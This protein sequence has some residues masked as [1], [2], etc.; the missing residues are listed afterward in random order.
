M[1]NVWIVVPVV[2]NDVDLTSMVENLSGGYTAP[3]T[4]N[5]YKFDVET[6]QT[7]IVSEPHPFAGQKG[8]DFSNKIIFVNKEAGYT[9]YDGV[10]H[11]EDFDDIS[12]Y[13]YWNSGFEYAVQNGAEAVIL[14][15][16]AMDLDTFALK[17]AYDVFVSDD[18]EIVNV[19][20]GAVLLMSAD[21]SVLPDT[22]FQ[23]WYGDN[24]IYRRAAEI[25]SSSR[26]DYFSLNYLI[27]PNSVDS[28]E[29]IVASDEA[30]YNAKWN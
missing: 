27:D 7:E 1:N 22:Q 14:L 17:D 9:E 24:D 11:I 25:S 26:S 18:K 29:S 28:F 6:N 21:S 19:A 2:S 10:V 12:I 20:D 30:K 13:R 3:E 23:I 8:P 15:N 16:G 4:Y 5:K